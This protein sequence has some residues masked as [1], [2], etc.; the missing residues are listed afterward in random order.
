MQRQK[1]FETPFKGGK[2]PE[3]LTPTGLPGVG[4]GKALDA[5]AQESGKGKG[6]AKEQSQADTRDLPKV[7]DL[8]R[9][10]A[11]FVWTRWIR[12]ISY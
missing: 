8:S 9:E 7:F 1:K 3:G 4:K 5:R 11:P 2:R 10:Q 6:R 12:L